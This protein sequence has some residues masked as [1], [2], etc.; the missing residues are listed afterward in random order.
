MNIIIGASH[1]LYEYYVLGC[2]GSPTWTQYILFCF[3]RKNFVL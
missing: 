3:R 1:L 2:L